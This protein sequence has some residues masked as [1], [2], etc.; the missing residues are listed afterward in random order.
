[1]RVS[2]KLRYDTVEARVNDA[3]EA[4]AHEMD[5]LASNKDIMKLS[6]G[7]VRAK[8]AIRYR[9]QIS[10]LGQFQKNIEFSK[11]LLTSSETA[12]AGISDNLIRLKELAIGMANDTNDGKS[13]D[14]TSRE[15]REIME[16]IV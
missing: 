6:D 14:A 13:R 9:D 15:V 11:G 10:D 5:R 8:Q 1:M 2:E 4:N 16:E 12:V 7:P 3:K